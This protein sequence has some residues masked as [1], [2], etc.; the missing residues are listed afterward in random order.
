MKRNIYRHGIELINLKKTWERSGLPIAFYHTTFVENAPSI[1]T[2]Q[3]I[4]ANKANSICQSKNGFIS[5]SDRITKGIIEFFGNVVFEFDAISLYRKNK[6]IAPRD[7]G[8]SEDAIEKYEELPFFENEW[9]TQK[10]LKFDLKDINKVLLI[11]S[12][13]FKE[14]SFKDVVRILKNKGIEYRF[15]SERWLADNIIPDITRYF[16]RI[17]NWEKFDKVQLAQNEAGEMK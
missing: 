1:L 13:D 9:I 3:K 2:Q 4:I 14:S 10:E 11:K 5:L 12:K 7:Y 6:S 8:I 17:E 16:F 15:L